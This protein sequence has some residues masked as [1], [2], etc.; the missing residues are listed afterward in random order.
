[1]KVYLYRTPGWIM[2]HLFD[3]VAD[4]SDITA[5]GNGR[6]IGMVFTL[7]KTICI[8]LLFVAFFGIF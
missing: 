1:M 4:D 8:F 2:G 6:L 7:R 3:F 5:L